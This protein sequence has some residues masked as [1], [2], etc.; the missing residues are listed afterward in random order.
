[1]QLRC[2]HSQRVPSAGGW[3][4]ISLVTHFKTIAMAIQT[5]NGEQP[6]G[7]QGQADVI[8][9]CGFIVS[10]SETTKLFGCEQNASMEAQSDVP[11]T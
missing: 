11:Q 5:Q 8:K 3:H 6:P 9:G 1:M 4:A 7:Q 10:P 2:P